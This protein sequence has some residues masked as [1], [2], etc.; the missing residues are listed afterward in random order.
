[1]SDLADF[2]LT[3]AVDAI[4][5]RKV[6]SLELLDACFA[7]IQLAGEE[8]NAFIWLD[9]EGARKFALRADEALEKG[10]WL[11][12]L[13]GIPL[14]H[15]DMF[16]REGKPCTCGSRIRKDFVPLATATVLARMDAA[17]AYSFG[18]LN[19]A[20]FGGGATGHNREFG[21]CHNPWN[22]AYVPGGSSSGSGATVAARMTYAALGSDTGG[23]IRLPAAA[24]GV[25]G[26]KPTQTRVSRYG[27][28]PQSFSLDNVG[29]LARTA[30]DCARILSV[31][32]GHDPLDPT[33]STE[34]VPIYEEALKG[35]ADGIKIGVPETHFLDN[36]DHAVGTAFD[37][38][39]G[40]LARRGVK[41]ECVPVPFI[42]AILAYGG[43]VDSVEAASIHAEW[44]R[45]RPQDVSAD[46]SWVYPGY[47]IPAT[48]YLEALSRRGPILREFS[49]AVFSRVDVLATPTI[50][51]CIPTLAETNIGH[52]L[53]E[54]EGKA[55]KL[56]A[57]SGIF[58]YLG[59]PT[60]SV[61]CG[62]DPNGMPI[63]L[64]FTGRPF[65]EAGILKLANAYQHETDWHKRRPMLPAPDKISSEGGVTLV[66]R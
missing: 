4:R 27:V 13:H 56:W 41:V 9:Y 44:M 45:S 50:P 52:Q 18:G 47:A 40:L 23:S 10:N 7:Q 39:V 14:A 58:N 17:G 12:P 11:G 48:Y 31:I 53:V 49:K 21:D 1:M 28:M 36:V 26:I 54:G 59:L 22:P 34:S 35:K 29:P 65:G 2:S 66:E 25:T 33:S 38:A 55:A 61:S 42:D 20:E 43:V 19:M 5:D 3:E 64:S 6:S 8:L 46:I 63:G 16:Y 62:F 24:C 51:T 15:K 37:N 57:N 30:V 32:A 60:V